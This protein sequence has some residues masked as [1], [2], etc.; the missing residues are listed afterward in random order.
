YR[1]STYVSPD[2]CWAGPTELV[3][4]A[5]VCSR[6]SDAG[7]VQAPRMRAST[8]RER[9]T[10]GPRGFAIGRSIAAQWEKPGHVD[11]SH[12]RTG[13]DACRAD[14]CRHPSALGAHYPL[15]ERRG[16]GRHDRLGLG[17][18]QC[19]AAVPLR[20]SPRDH[21]WRLACGR[22]ALALRG[23]VATGGGWGYFFC[24]LFWHRGGS[25]PT[26][27]RPARPRPGPSPKPPPPEGP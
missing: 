24:T 21:A 23:N 6:S 3:R 10:T 12:P 9:E 11:R 20:V 8:A 27:S 14:G 4:P 16:H 7:V 18:L 25:G 5:N 17:D 22:A 1:S 19:L 26:P 13:L 15:G 2:R